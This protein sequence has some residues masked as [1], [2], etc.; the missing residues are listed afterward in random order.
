MYYRISPQECPIVRTVRYGNETFGVEYGNYQGLIEFGGEADWVMQ[1]HTA[2][3]RRRH[4]GLEK[5]K[6]DKEPLTLA[7]SCNSKR[8]D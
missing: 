1:W 5:W 6:K 3:M 7:V 2:H 4:I 8:T